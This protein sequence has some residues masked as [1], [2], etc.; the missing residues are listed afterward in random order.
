MSAVIPR[1][2]LLFLLVSSVVLVGCSSERDRQWY[3]PGVNY[4]VAE[5]A[6]DR[7]DCTKDRVLDEQCM[8]ERGWVPLTS[9]R[10]PAPAPPKPSQG[11]RGPRY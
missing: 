8:K 11:P 7:D 9:D 10:G 5:F 2:C 6:R 3:K 4:T 1:G